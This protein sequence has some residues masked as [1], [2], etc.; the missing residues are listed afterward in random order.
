MK[1]DQT[2]QLLNNQIGEEYAAA[3]FYLQLSAWASEKGMKGAAAFFR[4]HSDE[5]F[6]HMYKVFDYMLEAGMLPIIP[7]LKS[8]QQNFEDISTAL[9]RAYDHEC[10]LTRKI[11]KIAQ[12][13]LDIGDFKT[14]DFIQWFIKEQMEEEGL[15]LDI[16]QKIE[17]LKGVEG[18][19]Y[20]IDQELQQF[21]ANHE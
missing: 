17:M 19:L 2:Y 1:F 11:Y 21:A 15:L 9:S 8:P 7:A 20:F 13:T 3:N 16:I 12:T 18:R 10:A 14:Y 5:E 4:K 6:I